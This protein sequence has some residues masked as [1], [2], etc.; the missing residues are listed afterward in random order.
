M[1][2]HI[3]RKF[4]ASRAEEKEVIYLK[5]RIHLLYIYQ[6]IKEAHRIYRSDTRV[7]VK[8]ITGPKGY[9]ISFEILL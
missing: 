1:Q 2:D 6:I 9:K 8:S 4:T 7:L 3:E 5:K